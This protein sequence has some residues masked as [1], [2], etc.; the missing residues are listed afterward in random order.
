[1]NRQLIALFIQ[2]PVQAKIIRAIF[3]SELSTVITVVSNHRDAGFK[4]ELL[5]NN[6]VITGS[7]VTRFRHVMQSFNISFQSAPFSIQVK[8]CVVEQHIRSH[9]KVI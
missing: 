7:Y 8:V 2:V 1:M 9:G 5:C 6:E 4:K 3:T